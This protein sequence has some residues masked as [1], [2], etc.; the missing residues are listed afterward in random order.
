MRISICKSLYGHIECSCI[1]LGRHVS[2]KYIGYTIA[3]A[4]TLFRA[5]IEAIKSDYKQTKIDRT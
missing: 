1:C 3:E 5:H 2:R 4:K